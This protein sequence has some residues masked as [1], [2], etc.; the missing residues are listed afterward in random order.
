VGTQK[1]EAFYIETRIINT[2]FIT[3]WHNISDLNSRLNFQDRARPARLYSLKTQTKTKALSLKTKIKTL[4]I[5]P[6]Y[7]SRSIFNSREL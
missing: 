6:Q 7:V 1:S 5:R 2:L 4:K 3:L